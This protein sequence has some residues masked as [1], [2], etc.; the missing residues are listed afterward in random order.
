MTDLDLIAEIERR[1]DEARA[2]IQGPDY[3]AILTDVAE[4]AGVP[5]E[6]LRAVWLDH[7]IAGAC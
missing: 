4:D 2:T 1:A 5:F 3:R 6:H 7:S